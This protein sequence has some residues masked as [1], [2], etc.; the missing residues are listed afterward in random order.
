[1]LS[2]ILMRTPVLD[3]F[4]LDLVPKCK[5]ENKVLQKTQ[6]LLLDV[7]GSIVMSYEVVLHVN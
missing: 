3:K 1:M 2:L 7:A 6:D 4:L 5:T